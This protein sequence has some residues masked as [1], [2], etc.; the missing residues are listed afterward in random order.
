MKNL[1]EEAKNYASGYFNP[2]KEMVAKNAF[3]AGAT[4]DYVKEQIILG[5]IEVLEKLEKQYHDNF[6]LRAILMDEIQTLKTK[7]K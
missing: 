3:E 1:E 2:E 7:L 5:Q 4:S 6:A